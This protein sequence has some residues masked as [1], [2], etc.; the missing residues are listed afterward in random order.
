MYRKEKVTTQRKMY[1]TAQREVAFVQAASVCRLLDVQQRWCLIQDS[2]ARRCVHRVH[3]QRAVCCGDGSMQFRPRRSN[4]Q[5]ARASFR[6]VR[7]RVHHRHECVLFP[8]PDREEEEDRA[9]CEPSRE[10]AP[11]PRHESP[12]VFI[13]SDKFF[14]IRFFFVLL[15]SIVHGEG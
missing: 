11:P 10:G 8:A 15:M 4:S 2:F 5:K 3:S 9:R 13:D 14:Y 1:E 6:L 12:R 7:V